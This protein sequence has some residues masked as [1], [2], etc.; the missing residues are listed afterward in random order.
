MA[1]G[2]CVLLRSKRNETRNVIALA[3]SLLFCSS[4]GRRGGSGRT[5]LLVDVVVCMSSGIDA[6]AGRPSGPERIVRGEVYV[7]ILATANI[8][9]LFSPTL[10]LI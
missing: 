1:S 10:M 4:G 8:A 3:A 9:A 5:I 6:S 7:R 2:V